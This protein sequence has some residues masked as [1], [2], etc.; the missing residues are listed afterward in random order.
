[1]PNPDVRTVV[2][3]LPLKL[4]DPNAHKERKLRETRTAYREALADAFD[5]NCSTQSAANDVVVD[6]ELSGYA[7]NALK[8]YVPQLVSE[9][10]NELDAEHPVRFTNEGVLL[11]HK[12]QNAI[13]W[14]VRVP[15]HEDYQLW[16]PAEPNPDQREWLVALSTGGA[17]MGEGR[18]IERD[19]TWYLHLTVKRD[20]A[21]S[22]SVSQPERTAVGVDIG[23]AALATVCHRDEYGTPTAPHCWTEAGAE[24]RRLR[25]KYC[26]AKKRLTKRDSS[27]VFEDLASKLWNRINHIIHRVTKEVVEYA[28]DLDDPVLVLEDLTNLRDGM[29]YGPFMN[30]R[31]HFWAYGKLRSQIEHKAACRGIP[32]VSV[33][34]QY[35]SQTCHACGTRGRRPDQGTFRCSNDECWVTEYQADINA[36][37]VLADQAP[38]GESQG[39]TERPGREKAAGDDSGG[40]GVSLTGPQDT[41][42]D[43]EG[44]AASGDPGPGS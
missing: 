36:A 29:D 18:L 17:E 6:H 43:T 16:L 21:L 42:D 28:A 14:Y 13:E 39:R 24:V 31:L 27:N 40:D 41:P 2:T 11:D 22:P 19:G 3:T 30:R 23:E 8:Q 7:K 35:T 12:P 37:I 34:P 10:A 5:Q 15:H 20:V 9:G 26:T 1:M 38:T 4:V 25:K 44:R 32:V 33:D